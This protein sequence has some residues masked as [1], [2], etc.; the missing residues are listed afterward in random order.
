MNIPTITIVPTI[1]TAFTCADTGTQG[2]TVAAAAFRGHTPFSHHGKEE[3][4]LR[5]EAMVLLL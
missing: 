4:G 2:S 3:E 1:T 5:H